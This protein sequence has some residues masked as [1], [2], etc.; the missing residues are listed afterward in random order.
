MTDDP[1]VWHYGL[2]AERWAECV[3]AAPELP[4]F[5]AAIARHGQ[6]VLDLGCGT[7]RL[8][9]PLLRAGIDIDGCDISA[10][11]LEQCRRKAAAEGLEARLYPAPM[12]T[13]QLPRRYR[14]IFMCGALGLAGSREKDLEALKRCH[15]HLEPGGALIFNIQAEYNRPSSWS[16]WLPEQRRALP[17]PWPESVEPC[18]A[19]DGSEHFGWFRV[20]AL[21]PF[22]QRCTLEVRLEKRVGGQVVAQEAYSLVENLYFKPEVMRMLELAGFRELQVTGDYS[23]APATAEHNE[24]VFTA[25]R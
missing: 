25:I 3:E 21:D 1:Q 11:M 12:H 15:A 10:D 19:A 23:D 17:Q 6:P 22:E 9:R 4:Y 14:T 2:M 8:L 16:Q 13:F 18:V 20:A 24:I 7:G 5:E